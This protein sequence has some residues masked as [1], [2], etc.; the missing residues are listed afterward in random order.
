MTDYLIVAEGFAMACGVLMAGI[1]GLLWRHHAMRPAWG[2]RWFA[3][4][5]ALAAVTDLL[6]PLLISGLWRDGVAGPSSPFVRLLA[7]MVGFGSL[8][9]LVVGTR[10]YVLRPARRPWGLF[11]ALWL[12]SQAVVLVSATQWNVPLVGDLIAAGFFLYVAWLA[13]GAARREPGVGHVLLGLVFLAQPVA[14]VVLAALGLELRAAR[15]YL[16]VP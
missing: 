2:L 9:A 14:L 10:H 11:L 6:S 4:A 5:M 3:A 8:A 13:L 15:Y 1:A 12:A 16:A 7:L